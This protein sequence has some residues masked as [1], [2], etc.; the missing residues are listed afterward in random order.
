[1]H[2]SIILSQVLT[3]RTSLRPSQIRLVL[4]QPGVARIVTRRSHRSQ[5]NPHTLLRFTPLGGYPA[6]YYVAG[7]QLREQGRRKP[8][9]LAACVLA[10]I[11]RMRRT[12]YANRPGYEDSVGPR[13]SA[14][15]R[16]RMP[17]GA[18]T[19][20]QALAFFARITRYSNNPLSGS[21]VLRRST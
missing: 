14:T 19:A 1:M 4:P 13:L 17:Y 15:A 11:C 16:I 8:P 12:L 2:L 6:V 21:P 5:G 18:R 9:R 10:S 20:Y 7:M 3:F